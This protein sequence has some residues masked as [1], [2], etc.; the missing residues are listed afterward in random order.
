MPLV[1]LPLG[2]FVQHRSG[3][4]KNFLDIKV[5]LTLGPGKRMVMCAVYGDNKLTRFVF[6]SERRGM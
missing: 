4:N 5:G 3:A 1:S 6:S 2:V